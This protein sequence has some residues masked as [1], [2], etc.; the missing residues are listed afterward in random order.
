MVWKYPVATYGDVGVINKVVIKHDA[1]DV[2][3]HESPDGR[4]SECGGFDGWYVDDEKGR[5]HEL[6]EVEAAE[7]KNRGRRECAAFPQ[8]RH[9][10]AGF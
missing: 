7:G 8:C 3:V 6:M 2:Y 10:C 1:I 4:F 5:K 9:G